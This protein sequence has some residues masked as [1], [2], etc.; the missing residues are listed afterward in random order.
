M[1]TTSNWFNCHRWPTAADT[2]HRKG[3]ATP[4]QSGEWRAPGTTRRPAN[5]EAKVVENESGFILIGTRKRKWF[6]IYRLNLEIRAKSWEQKW[7]WKRGLHLLRCVNRK[8]RPSDGSCVEGVVWRSQ[9]KAADKSDG[10]RSRIKQ[11]L[12]V[13]LLTNNLEMIK[14]KLT[15][16]KYSNSTELNPISIQSDFE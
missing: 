3:W 13:K 1:M 8:S 12:K 16:H 15:N 6:W 4:F 10:W 9:T 5:S 2:L 14:I 7:I 11:R